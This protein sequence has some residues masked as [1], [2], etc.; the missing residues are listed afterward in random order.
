MYEIQI[1]CSKYG[2]HAEMIIKQQDEFSDHEVKLIRQYALHYW[3][4]DDI[5][6]EIR[7]PLRKAS[8]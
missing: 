6:I 8:N 2:R 1:I 3:D 5:H 7:W 4:C